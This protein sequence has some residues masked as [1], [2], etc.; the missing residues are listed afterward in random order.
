MVLSGAAF[1]STGITL[2]AGTPSSTDSASPS[3]I[4]VSLSSSATSFQQP[5]IACF[6]RK[7]WVP[8]STG[9]KERGSDEKGENRGGGNKRIQST[10]REV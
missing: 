10:Q 8:D 9:G 4:P 1:F 7:S 6:S 3:T 2:I 5:E